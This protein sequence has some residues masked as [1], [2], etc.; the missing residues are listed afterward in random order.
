MSDIFRFGTF[1]VDPAGR[2]LLRDGERIAVTSKAFDTLLVLVS[3]AGQTVE[4]EEILREVWPSTFISDETLAQNISTLRR[5]LGDE[6]EAPR[7]IATVP[8]RGYR[9]VMPV[10][11]EQDR[12]SAPTM[13]AAPERAQPSSVRRRAYILTAVVITAVVLVASVIAVALLPRRSASQGLPIRFTIAAPEGTRL[14]TSG[15][16]FA[17]SPDSRNLAFIATDLSG[18]DH[19]WL[20]PF[21]DTAARMLPG[22]EGASQPFW[23]PDSRSVAFFS[24]DR[25]NAIDIGNEV[26]R[27]ICRSPAPRAVAGSWSVD[28]DIIF[29]AIRSGLFRVRALGGTAVELALPDCAKCALWPQFLPDGRHFLYTSYAPDGGRAGVFVAS[30]DSRESR[31]VLSTPSSTV[32]VTTGYLLYVDHGSLNAR[33]FDPK[34]MAVT[35]EAREVAREVAWNASTGRGAFSASQSGVIVF[36][37]VTPARLTWFSRSGE[38]LGSVGPLGQYDSFAISP[39]G[40]RVAA[41]LLNGRLG[42]CDLW[43]FSDDGSEATRL[44]FDPGSELGPMWAADGRHVVYSGESGGTWRVLAADISRSGVSRAI[45]QVSERPTF[46]VPLGRNPEGMLL[47][48]PGQSR[49]GEY[50]VIRDTSVSRGAWPAGLVPSVDARISPDG[51]WL[52][53]GEPDPDSRPQRTPLY[54]RALPPA[55]GRWQIAP[56]ASEPR[57]RADSRELFFLGADL[58]VRSVRIDTA[59]GSVVSSPEVLLRPILVAPSGLTGQAYDVSPDGKRI[60]AKTPAGQQELVVFVNWSPQ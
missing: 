39:D 23:S 22:T 55:E 34:R 7:Y 30:L 46:A 13:Q 14:S 49:G 41:A 12:V 15:G 18:D 54:V 47:Y 24:H 10:G 1:T 48:T 32:F 57:W 2:R 56:E 59:L 9:F 5:V 3:R 37:P 52:A 38:Q 27:S 25:L 26:V 19:L 20:R 43:L 6:T 42:T 35:G 53:Y 8:R 11:R 36:R 44:T 21:Q 4:K 60:L 17:V 31:K 28:G 50:W 40:H 16:G 51:R 29:G 33:P 58:A 45:A